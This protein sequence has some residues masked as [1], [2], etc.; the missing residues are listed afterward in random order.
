[1]TRPATKRYRE[2]RQRTEPLKDERTTG[3]PSPMCAW[4]QAGYRHAMLWRAKRG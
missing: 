3:K 2:P 4:Q 1:M